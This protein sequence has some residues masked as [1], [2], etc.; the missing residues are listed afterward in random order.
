MLTSL[1]KYFAGAAKR[2]KMGIFMVFA[3]FSFLMWFLIK[4]SED[5]TYKVTFKVN[6]KNIPDDKLLLNTPQGTIDA[7]VSASG[8]KIFNYNLFK[9]NIN[10]D[11]SAYD[12][13]EKGFYLVESD[14][15]QEIESQYNELPLRRVLTDTIHIQYGVNKE[16]YVKIV[17]DMNLDFESDYELYEDVKVVPDSMWILGPENIVDSISILKTV[18]YTG[19]DINANI[20]TTLAIALPEHSDRL[21]FQTKNVNVSA[22]VEKFSEKII[23]TTV[24]VNN[25]PDS[26]SVRTFPATVN[27]LV[28]T[29]LKDLKKITPEDFVVVGNYE[30]PTAENK[31]KLKIDQAPDI[32]GEVK[33]QIEEVEFLVKRK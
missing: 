25:V 1:K 7:I 6:Y 2:K 24:I 15:E 3:L 31:L 5:Y 13:T 11:L 28:R 30:T 23:K 19:N 29:A 21:N 8:F 9:R 12:D 33:L 27:I 26:L 17:P 32:V 14:L 20:N 18:E 22:R 16:K 4:L 10:I